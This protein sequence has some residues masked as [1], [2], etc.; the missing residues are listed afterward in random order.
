MFGRQVFIR[1]VVLK[2]SVKQVAEQLLFDQLRMTSNSGLYRCIKFA[3]SNRPFLW[4]MPMSSSAWTGV[5]ARGFSQMTCLP[6]LSLL[7]LIEMQKRRRR[8]V[9]EIYFRPRQQAIDLI[10]IIESKSFGGRDCSGRAVAAIPARRMPGVCSNCC[11]ANKPKPPQPMIP[12]PI[13]A[14]MIPPFCECWCLKVAV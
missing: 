3:T 14:S 11:R 9:D 4:A 8:D 1:R 5:N 13:S 6:A 10:E 12:R 2:I 7:R